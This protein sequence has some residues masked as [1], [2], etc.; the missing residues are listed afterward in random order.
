MMDQRDHRVEDAS[1]LGLMPG[2][3]PQLIHIGHTTYRRRE[4]T[5]S[6]DGDVLSVEYISVEDG[7]SKLI[8]LND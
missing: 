7:R 1:T 4:M 3:W 2:Q 5:K 6:N 8:V